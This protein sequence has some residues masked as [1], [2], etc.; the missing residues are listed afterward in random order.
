MPFCPECR[1]EFQ[2]WVEVCPNCKVALIDKLKDIP[3]PVS[4]IESLVH[5]ATAPNEAIAGMWAGILE[6][7]GILSVLKSSDFKSAQYSLLINQHFT[8]HVLE[9]KA[10]KAKELLSPFEDDLNDYVISRGN[11]LSLASRIFIIVAFLFFWR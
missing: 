5:V 8:I 1:D 7:N 2:D 3:K 11:C 6:N 10:L 4:Q 9:P